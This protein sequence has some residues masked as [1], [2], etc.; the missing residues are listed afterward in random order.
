MSNIRMCEHCGKQISLKNDVW[1]S[2]AIGYS[3]RGFPRHHY[4]CNTCRES[5]T[6]YDRYWLMGEQP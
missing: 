3:K 1:W 4:I 2:T 5:S 6:L